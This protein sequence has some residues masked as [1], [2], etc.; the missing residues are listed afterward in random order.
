[1]PVE[2]HSGGGRS[3]GVCA[4]PWPSGPGNLRADGRR[5]GSSNRRPRTSAKSVTNQRAAE[6]IAVAWEAVILALRC[7][8]RAFAIR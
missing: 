6:R 1:M 2:I 8:S 4:D 5:N 3:G 7:Q